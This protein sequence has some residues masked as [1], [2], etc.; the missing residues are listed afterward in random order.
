M[1]YESL[2]ERA[3]A[4]ALDTIRNPDNDM[5]INGNRYRVSNSLKNTLQNTNIQQITRLMKNFSQEK[6]PYVFKA[7]M[8]YK[9]E[10]PRS[11][12]EHPK[13]VIWLY[14]ALKQ[15]GDKELMDEVM[16][17][18]WSLVVH[19]NIDSPYLK[20]IVN[21]FK[22]IQKYLP[23]VQSEIEILKDMVSDPSE[24]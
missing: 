6:Q 16:R 14:M 5:Q 13:Y 21:N 15:T 20:Q 2:F 19:N 9:P 4:E 12:V 22:K 7:W 3:I 17:D 18:H 23:W 1:T 11:L 10:E 8:N 24:I